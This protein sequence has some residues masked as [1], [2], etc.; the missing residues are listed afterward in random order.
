VTLLLIGLVGGVVTG[1][2]PC[3]LITVAGATGRIGGGTIQ[4]TAGFAAGTAATLLVFAFAGKAVAERVRVFRRRQRTIR[5]V[6]GVAVVTLALGLT[7][8]VA[9]AVQRTIPDY[10]TAVSH[11]LQKLIPAAPPQKSN[12]G[13]ALAE[14]VDQA[15]YGRSGDNCGPAPGFTGV[16]RWLNTPDG[17]PL[18]IASLHG[19]VVLVDFWTFDCVNCRHVL[20]YVNDWYR[21]YHAAGF[22]VVGVHTPEY[23]FEHDING[24]TDAAARFGIRYPIA[25]DNDYANW[26][27]YGV[28][29]WP[30]SF[31][32]DP[33]GTIRHISVGEG[34]YDET[35]K[36][37]QSLL[38]MPAA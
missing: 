4:L 21:K 26:Q 1:L 33:T 27:N 32:V 23:H 8:D 19:K 10:T 29:A 18:D 14:C 22:E 20:P 3:I 2:S 12:A 34:G 35:E 38:P 7:F 9:G 37:I 11:G 5:V 36:L 24:V 28:Q 30:S 17:K 13:Q 31:L 6:S 15:L 25:V 16:T